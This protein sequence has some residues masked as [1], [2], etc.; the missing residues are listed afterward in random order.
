MTM[1]LGLGEVVL[2]VRDLDIMQRFY[3]DVCRAGAAAPEATW[4]SWF[5]TTPI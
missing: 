1:L 2:R 4:W 5:A 3:Q